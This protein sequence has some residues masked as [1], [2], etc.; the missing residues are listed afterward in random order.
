MSTISTTPFLPWAVK[1]SATDLATNSTLNDMDSDYQWVDQAM[2]IESDVGY[3]YKVETLACTGD[4]D[5]LAW[6][7]NPVSSLNLASVAAVPEYS[8]PALAAVGDA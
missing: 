3:P 2:V 1:S 4:D 8:L 6:Q 7:Q 5:F